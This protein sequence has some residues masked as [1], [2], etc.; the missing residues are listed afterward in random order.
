MH[1][2]EIEYFI[3]GLSYV[4]NKFYFD[5]IEQFKKIIAE[6]P[7]SELCDDAEYNISLCYFELNQFESAI[8]NLNKLI[9]DYPDGTITV[10]GAGNEFGRTA[11]KAY[12]LTINC[13]LGL[14]QKEKAFEILPIIKTYDD[15][16]VVRDGKKVTYFRLAEETLDLFDKIV[17]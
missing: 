4:N 1:E 6:F 12:L 17:K 8:L 9:Q 13:Y 15:S 16:Y 14:G 7:G 10:L 3:K 2:L 5:A 11:A